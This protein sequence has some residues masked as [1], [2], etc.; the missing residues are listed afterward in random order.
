MDYKD[1]QEKY[2]ELVEN[3]KTGVGGLDTLLSLDNIVKKLVDENEQIASMKEMA[4]D[5]SGELTSE[6]L[7][8]LNTQISKC[9]KTTAEN[10]KDT[11]RED[12][13]AIKSK[14]SNIMSNLTTLGTTLPT[15]AVGIGCSFTS[16]ASVISAPAGI[17]G[18]VTSV[19]QINQIKTI[20][21]SLKNDTI[22]IMGLLGK[23]HISSPAAFDAVLKTIENIKQTI[24]NIMNLLTGGGDLDKKAEKAQKR[25]IKHIKKE[26]KKEGCAKK[27]INEIVDNGK[28][29]EL[30]YPYRPGDPEGD[31]ILIDE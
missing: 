4:N 31:E 3:T 18:L 19:I 11:V 15:M 13:D 20:V 29:R 12:I 8:S 22:N 23:L 30:Y 9:E 1:L 5:L 7:E 26:M 14:A 17:A 28:D 10:M 6:S 2:K 25:A 24:D 21:D 16:I 27:D